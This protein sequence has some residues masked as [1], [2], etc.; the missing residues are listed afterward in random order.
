[1]EDDEET[2]KHLINAELRLNKYIEEI[3]QQKR[4]K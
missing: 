4:L 3:F 1:L 2:Y